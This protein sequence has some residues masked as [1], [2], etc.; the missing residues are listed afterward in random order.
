MYFPFVKSKVFKVFSSVSEC[1]IATARNFTSKTLAV[2]RVSF[3][4]YFFRFVFER[5]DIF[6]VLCRFDG[7]VSAATQPQKIVQISDLAQMSFDAVIEV[8]FL[9]LNAF[10]SIGKVPKNY[11][12]V[13]DRQFQNQP[14]MVCALRTD[15]LEKKCA[16]F[17]IQRAAAALKVRVIKPAATPGA[18]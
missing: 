4:P 14:A 16:R 15:V 7:T 8:G 9:F 17:C 6:G 12:W 13:A 3:A 1:R 18:R 2:P 10:K 11:N 5:R